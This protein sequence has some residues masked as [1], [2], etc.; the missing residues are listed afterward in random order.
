VDPILAPCFFVIFVLIS[1]FVLVNVVVAVLMKHL[2]ESNKREEAATAAAVAI[3]AGHLPPSGSLEE[4][5][6]K[7]EDEDEEGDDERDG[8][9][10]VR[11]IP[12][13]R[14]AKF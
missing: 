9:K 5:R 14:K 1:Q 10:I 8:S 7:D 6:E 4:E 11:F 12:S 2:E 13:L 3:E